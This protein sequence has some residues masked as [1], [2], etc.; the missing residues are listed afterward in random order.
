[1]RNFPEKGSRDMGCN[2]GPGPRGFSGQILEPALSEPSLFP[3][4][5]LHSEDTGS[6]W[7]VSLKPSLAKS[8]YIPISVFRPQLCSSIQ[9]FLATKVTQAVWGQA[10]TGHSRGN[11]FCKVSLVV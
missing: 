11:A 6:S 5:R 7:S 3:L 9:L 1:M 10:G 8:P 2:Q 4:Q